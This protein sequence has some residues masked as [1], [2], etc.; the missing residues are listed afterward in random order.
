MRARPSPFPWR[1]NSKFQVIPQPPVTIRAGAA[2]SGESDSA[3]AAR[4]ASIRVHGIC[5]QPVHGSH[6]DDDAVRSTG[7][8]GSIENSLM[9][10]CSITDMRMVSDFLSPSL[11]VSGIG[12]ATSARRPTR[13]CDA[14]RRCRRKTPSQPGGA[15]LA[16]RPKT[17][18][19]RFRCPGSPGDR[20]A[21]QRGPI[22]R[23]GPALGVGIL[24]R[25]QHSAPG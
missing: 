2:A 3:G 6:R 22:L 9:L 7:G 17:H 8:S 16:R 10:P 15:A 21:G 11:W 4:A 1:L 5:R 14:R 12:L 23:I 24:R 18:R 19:R 25:E 13:P 20:N